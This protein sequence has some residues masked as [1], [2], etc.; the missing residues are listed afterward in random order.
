MYVNI[1]TCSLH[2]ITRPLFPTVPGGIAFL[3]KAGTR[4]ISSRFR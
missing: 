2:N 4:G 1:A 3:Q